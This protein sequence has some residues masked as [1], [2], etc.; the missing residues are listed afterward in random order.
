LKIL[1]LFF[2]SNSLLA[3][4]LIQLIENDISDSKQYQLE[5]PNLTIDRLNLRYSKQDESAGDNQFELRVSPISNKE[6]GL[7]RKLFKNQ[8]ERFKLAGQNS[9]NFNI[10]Q[11]YSKY[12]QYLF[13]RNE[14][15]IR[16]ELAK[17][18]RDYSLVVESFIKRGEEKMSSFL[19]VEKVALENIVEISKLSKRIKN[20][21]NYKELKIL[22]IDKFS[23]ELK[24]L[25]TYTSILLEL[26]KFESNKLVD[27]E[28]KR[29]ELEKSDL[30]LSLDVS[31]ESSLVDFVGVELQRKQFEGDKYDNRLALKVSL[32]IPSFKGDKLS[33]NEDRLKL[34]YSKSKAAIELS[35][36]TDK[37]S[38]LKE[39]IESDINIINLISNSNFLK[40]SNR[41][42]DQF[43]KQKGASPLKLIELKESIVQSKLDNS[44]R[45]RSIYANYLMYLCEK[46]LLANNRSLNILET[47]I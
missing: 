6:S 22:N 45:Q 44:N 23:S 43:K 14:L 13:D 35:T 31:K 12:I 26:K 37:A 18:L 36:L 19:K 2:L 46:G 34:I 30:E 16:T 32:N 38:E 40:K 24:R 9:L 47:K 5:Q 25:K 39:S 7:K 27:L 28:Y 1:F 11:I 8:N 15:S 33:L 29:L 42:L 10:H 4:N 41:Y 17:V 20:Y 21:F 3:A